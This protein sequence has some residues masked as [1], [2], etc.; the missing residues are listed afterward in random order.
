MCVRYSKTKLMAGVFWI[1]IVFFACLHGVLV[2]LPVKPVSLGF[3]TYDFQSFFITFVNM[4]SRVPK[5]PVPVYDPEKSYDI[6]KAEL[7]LW[8]A[9]TDVA[10]EKRAASVVFQLPNTGKCNVRQ[11]VM[12][13]V[14]HEKLISKTGLAEVKTALDEILIYTN[15]KP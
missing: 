11:S 6:F 14:D 13:K 8:E 5:I 1:F 9:V 7:K 4:T 2:G 15:I 12:E 10:E 3:V